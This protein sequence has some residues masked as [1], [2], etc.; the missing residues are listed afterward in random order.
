[1]HL[2]YSPE[3]S[4]IRKNHGMKKSTERGGAS[5]D[6]GNTKRKASANDDRTIAAPAKKRFLQSYKAESTV[7]G[8][9]ENISLTLSILVR[10]YT[11]HT[12]MRTDQL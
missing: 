1:M 12:V 6:I 11:A 8:M 3:V 9:L 4:S 10:Y 2:K 7:K 5:K